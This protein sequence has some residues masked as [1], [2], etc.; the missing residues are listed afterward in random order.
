MTS[1]FAVEGYYKLA[2][3]CIVFNVLM[4]NLMHI[5]KIYDV[6]FISRLVIILL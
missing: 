1:Q 3:C 5:E 4:F 2:L 6:E